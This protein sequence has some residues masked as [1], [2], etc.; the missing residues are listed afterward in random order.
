MVRSK[1]FRAQAARLLKLAEEAKENGNSAI[2]SR[3]TDAA[4]RYQEQ[5]VALELREDLPEQKLIA[6]CRPVFPV[7]PRD[8]DSS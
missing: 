2:A 5:A 1:W 6:T 3:L 7:S 8:F 4:A